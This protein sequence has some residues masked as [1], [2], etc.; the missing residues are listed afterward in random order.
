MFGQGWFQA[1][2][3]ELVG[4]DHVRF[5]Y[6]KAKH[7][8]GEISRVRKLTEL[9]SI[10]SRLNRVDLVKGNID[11]SIR[12]IETHPAWMTSAACDDP[13][14]F[15]LVY[16]MPTRYIFS[17]DHRLAQCRGHMNRFIDSRFCAFIVISD[18]DAYRDHRYSILK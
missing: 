13:H 3:P 14:I 7:M 18:L 2:L 17:Q 1:M 6:S 9:L 16:N 8:A 11:R 4:S 10:M 5:S 15:A 12:D